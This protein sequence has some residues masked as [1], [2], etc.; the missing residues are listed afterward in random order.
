M[1][2]V[3]PGRSSSLFGYDHWLG[4]FQIGTIVAMSCCIVFIV[5]GV[6]QP[7]AAR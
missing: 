2:R 3:H 1:S 7:G 4:L 6:A 5:A